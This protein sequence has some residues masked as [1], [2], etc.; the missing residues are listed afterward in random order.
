MHGGRAVV[1]DLVPKLLE[2][3]DQ[4]V[5]AAVDV[6]DNVERS[7][8]G[9]PVRPRG[10]ALDLDGLH[11]LGA[12]EDEDTAESFSVEPAEGALQLRELLTNN[13]PTEIPVGSTGVA[14]DAQPLRQV[15]HDCHWQ[16]VMRPGEPPAGRSWRR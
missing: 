5:V 8:I 3:L 11:L 12:A 14:I 15:E 6:A 2:Q 7:V 1:R 4:L 13:A 16:D 10:L 9:T